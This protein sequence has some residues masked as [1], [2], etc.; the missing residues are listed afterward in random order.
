MVT[1]STDGPAAEQVGCGRIAVP[2]ALLDLGQLLACPHAFF[3]RSL[4][5]PE[6]DLSGELVEA[7]PHCVDDLPNL[8]IPIADQGNRKEHE[9]KLHVAS[10]LERET[11]SAHVTYGIER[12]KCHV[13]RCA[14]SVPICSNGEH[15]PGH[16]GE[17][18]G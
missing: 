12:W 18:G 2:G 8:G 3:A 6:L 13:T 14:N 4:A 11:D 1:T 17:A 7:L 10:K 16:R 9:L 15:R 5:A